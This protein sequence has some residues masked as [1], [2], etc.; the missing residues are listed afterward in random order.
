MD[1]EPLAKHL[2][3]HQQRKSYISQ[4]DQ[5]PHLCVQFPN[6]LVIFVC[7]ISKPCLTDQDS[8]DIISR[9]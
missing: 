3:P 2:Q 6:E 5:L 7:L 9:Q 1:L 4:I 8:I